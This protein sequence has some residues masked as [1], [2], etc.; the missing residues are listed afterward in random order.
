[1]TPRGDGQTEMTFATDQ[2]S[3]SDFSLHMLDMARDIR[4][5]LSIL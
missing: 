5:L 3:A 2:L 1:M 4:N